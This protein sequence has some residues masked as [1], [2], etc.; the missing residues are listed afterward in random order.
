MKHTTVCWFLIVPLSCLLHPGSA[1]AQRAVDAQIGTWAVEGSADATLYS[2]ALWR[3]AWGRGPFGYS[4]RALGLIDRGLEDNSLYGF[5]PELTLL[6]GHGDRA[7]LSAYAAGGV[8]LAFQS[9]GSDVSALWSAGLGLELRAPSLFSVTVEARRLVEDTGVN[10]F[11]D[12][13]EGDRQGWLLALGLSVRWGGGAGPSSATQP[14]V[15]SVSA[16]GLQREIVE[17]A[18]AAMG[19]P[20]R[21]GGTSTDEGGGVRLLGT[22]LVRVSLSRCDATARQSRPG[23]GGPGN[24]AEHRRAGA[25]RHPHLLQS[26]RRRHARGALHRRRP[27]H[28]RHDLG[29]RSD[30][31]SR[32][33]T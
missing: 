25:G 33:P 14:A 1:H 19:E 6:R 5:G 13:R 12:L 2:A 7:G 18:L 27:L 29:R 15:P 26:T 20:Y 28:P 23:A 32:Y 3:S 24:L 4:F 9:N 16:S 22:R 30:W 21:W 8:S 10:G 17:T 11:W 31:S